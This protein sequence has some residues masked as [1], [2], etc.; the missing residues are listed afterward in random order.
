VCWEG[1]GNLGTCTRKNCDY[2]SNEFGEPAFDA[3]GDPFMVKG[4]IKLKIMQPP[5]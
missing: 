2:Y 1:P 3:A 5:P 4:D